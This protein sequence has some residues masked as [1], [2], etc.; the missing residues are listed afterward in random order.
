[1]NAVCAR[2]LCTHIIHVQRHRPQTPEE[3][4]PL[5][6]DGGGYHENEIS[7]PKL[8]T[9]GAQFLFL[10]Q[11]LLRAQLRGVPALLL[12]AVL[13]ARRQPGVAFT[14]DHTVAVRLLRE[15][16]E[17]RVN[18]SSAQ[19]QHEVQRRLLLDVVVGQRAPVLELFAGE[20]QALLIRRD[21]AR[22]RRQ[23]EIQ[24][25]RQESCKR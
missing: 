22:G 9:Q 8:K 4:V 25:R 15:G 21:A 6:C 17:G 10:L 14:A 12:A 7:L 24:A 19:A 18:R 3:V 1:M 16:C 20:N 11:L 5:L 13:R 2:A 23:A